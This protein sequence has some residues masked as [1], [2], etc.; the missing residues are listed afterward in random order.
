M[1]SAMQYLAHPW[2][3]HQRAVLGASLLDSYC[4]FLDDL[5][6]QSWHWHSLLRRARVWTTSIDRH[7]QRHNRRVELF[8]VMSQLWA[9]ERATHRVE[10][11][12][13]SANVAQRPASWAN[14]RHRTLPVESDESL[15]PLRICGDWHTHDPAFSFSPLLFRIIGL[16]YGVAVCLPHKR[17]LWYTH[18]NF[19]SLPCAPRC[20]NPLYHM[21][22]SHFPKHSLE[23]SLNF[24]SHSNKKKQGQCFVLL[25][26]CCTTTVIVFHTCVV[27]PH[28]LC[29]VPMRLLQC[30]PIPPHFSPFPPHFAPF[31][32][33]FPHFPPAS[34]GHHSP[35]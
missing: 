11:P 7:Y 26:W 21:P 35:L 15:S 28:R 24:W 20:G 2:F 1:A 8:L 17:A 3:L 27:S 34:P 19:G 12:C 18:V 23:Y 31:P 6:R 5:V 29:I 4:G 32:P 13:L 10:L 30:S 33:S 22:E 25:R 14:A 16:P 9:S